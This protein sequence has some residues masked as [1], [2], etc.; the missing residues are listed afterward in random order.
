[1]MILLWGLQN[2][3]RCY[4]G[5]YWI[6]ETAPPTILSSS[7]EFPL[8]KAFVLSAPSLDQ[9]NTISKLDHA[10]FKVQII[11]SR[12]TYG[13]MLEYSSTNNQVCFFVLNKIKLW[14]IN[15]W[16]VALTRKMVKKLIILS[17]GNICV[18]NYVCMP[19]ILIQPK[20]MVI[21]WYN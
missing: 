14:F 10:N 20:N 4:I 2:I 17:S 11:F 6:S 8:T 16:R 7:A 5:N 1:M 18:G 19:K 13:S 15:L 12:A 21:S 3:Y 9:I